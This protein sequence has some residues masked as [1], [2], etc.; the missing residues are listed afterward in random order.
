MTFVMEEDVA[1]NPLDVDRK[2]GGS[3]LINRM[4]NSNGS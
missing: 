2:A 4:L 1:L 3:W